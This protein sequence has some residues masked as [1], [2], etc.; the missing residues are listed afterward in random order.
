MPEVLYHGRGCRQCQGTG[1]HGRTGIFEIMPVNETLRA[2]ILERASA[3]DIRKEAARGGMS[4]LREDGWRLVRMGNTTLEEVLR[5]TKEDR[6]NSNGNKAVEA[7]VTGP[8]GALA[9]AG[10]E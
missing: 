10:D 8:D 1:Y 7:A 9:Q 3:G 4:S 6:L 2:M 5:A